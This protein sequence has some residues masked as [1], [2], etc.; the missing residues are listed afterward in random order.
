M[1]PALDPYL[2]LEDSHS[3][4][5]QHWLAAQNAKTSAQLDDDPRFATMAASILA[6][7]QDQGQIPYFSM[8]GNVCFNFH[9]DAQHIRGIY[10]SCHIDQYTAGNTQWQTLLDLDALAQQEQVDWF[11]N[12]VDHC[13]LA[14]HRCLLSL[15][16]GGGDACVI[17]EY[18][19]AAQSFVADGFA[20]PYSKTQ[21]SWR[22]PDSV[23]VCPAWDE[24]QV[25]HTGYSREVVLLR[26]GQS[27]AEAA[28]MLVL[29]ETVFKVSA[30]RFLD[31]DRSVLDMVQVSQD[32]Y[33]K[34]YFHLNAD[35]AELAEPQ[36]LALPSR[37]S[38]EAYSHGDLIIHLHADWRYGEQDHEQVFPAGSA[39]A[40]ACDPVSAALGRA[41]LLF[42]PNATQSLQMIEA[43]LNGVLL[44]ILDNVTSRIISFI[45]DGNTWQNIPNAIASD[46][47]IEIVAQPW[48]SD[49]LYF[50]FSNFLSPARLQRYELG[51]QTT[52]MTLRQQP[53]AFNADELTVAQYRAISTDGTAIPYFVVHRK[54]LRFDGRNP[55]L[56]Y[57]YGGFAVPILPYYLDN[58]GSQW[59]SA[60]GVYVLANI[61]GG[62]EF[63]PAWHEAARGA[64][65]QTSF[66]DFIAVAKDL[67]A[68][69]IT[70]AAHLGI[71]GGSNGGL[72][73]ASCMV[74][75]PELFAAVVCEVPILD[76]LRFDQLGAGSSWIAE[77]GNP[78]V[79]KDAAYLGVYSPYANIKKHSEQH[80]PRVLIT[81]NLNDDR[82]HPAHGRK[83]AAKLQ[84][85]GHEVLF[86]EAEQGG[87]TG[88]QGQRQ[89]AHDLARV[90]LFLRQT[91]Q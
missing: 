81:T 10:R 75:A 44:I 18:D 38:I 66:A 90:L 49:V 68:R 46:G 7:M 34:S 11:L 71:E 84:D 16:I 28:S 65:R 82:V 72:L 87:H 64:K 77:Y 74:Q 45:H 42:A 22:D 70:S 40:L 89:T 33:R 31:G 69:Q 58:L 1:N 21:V 37:A 30:W 59:L 63:G 78:Q 9:Q 76:M 6:N 17:R 25:T 14:P 24:D 73:V 47:V 32:F 23:F 62:G 56:L 61:R 86:Y 13:T 53:D 4:Q 85:L 27:W 57:G 79:E 88:Q 60:G 52:P 48:R 8:H 12:G 19:L 20:F 26:R 80:Y 29:P 35:Q 43:T 54:D 41:E 36:Y 55:T 3:E 83:M 2:F 15:S 91:L 5:A 67:I 51:A 39:I 50:N